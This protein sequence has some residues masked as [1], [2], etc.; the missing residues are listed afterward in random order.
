MGG[1]SVLRR[2][3]AAG[4]GLLEPPARAACSSRLLGRPART[5]WPDDT[6]L[7]LD[8]VVDAWSRAAQ[9]LEGR[10]RWRSGHRSWV[11]STRPPH[12]LQVRSAGAAYRPRHDQPP[13]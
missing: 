1:S 11:I 10:W 4:G 9:E 5:S 12:A 13:P 3:G 6:D 7:P 8:D 2:A